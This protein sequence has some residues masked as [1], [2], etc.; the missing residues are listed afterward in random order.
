MSKVSTPNPVAM[1]RTAIVTGGL[2]G[3][4]KAI[5]AELATLGH[6]VVIGSRNKSRDAQ[7]AEYDPKQ[8]VWL[9]LDV[10]SS[11]SVTRFCAEVTAFSG[12]A[13]ILVNNAGV[14]VHQ[15]I[16]G[17]SDTDWNNVINTNLSGPFKMIR[18]CLPYMMDNHWG[19]IINIASTAAHTADPTHV[20]YCASKSGLLGLSRAVALEGAAAGVTCVTVSPTWVETDMLHRSAA[21][22]AQSREIT[23]ADVIK[24]LSTSNPQNR[25]VQ[26]NE[27]A[28]LV[29]F[30]CGDSASAITMEDIQVS[31]GAHW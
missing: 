14:S 28:S 26:A 11:E 31:A 27:I 18:A 29:A 3:I 15:N 24:E 25:L 9:P 19:R 16:M 2:Q 4:G 10:T 8:V 12:G 22:M 23:T 6:R 30:L 1:N 5:V 7:S 20:A 21:K 17:H 13:D